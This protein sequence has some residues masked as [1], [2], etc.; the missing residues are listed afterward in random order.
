MKYSATCEI[1]KYILA[2][3]KALELVMLYEEEAWNGFAG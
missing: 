3:F 2:A 1:C